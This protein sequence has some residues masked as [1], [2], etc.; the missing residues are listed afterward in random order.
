MKRLLSLTLLTSLALLGGCDLAQDAYSKYIKPS[1]ATLNGYTAE[2]DASGAPTGKV[3]LNISALDNN[4]EPIAGD[5]SKPVVKDIK[6]TSTGGGVRAAQTY[7]ATAEIKFDIKV[8]EIV[9][10][11]LDIDQSGSMKQTD[12]ARKRVDAA[13]SFIGRIKGDDRLA[14]MTFQGS[15]EGYRASSLL[16][17]FTSDKTALDAAVQKVGQ[18]N[19]TPIW[20]SVLDTLDLHDGDEGG[21]NA[22]RVVVLFT[23]GQRNGG[24]VNFPEALGAASES[25][26]KFFT[27]GLGAGEKQ[28]DLT[29]L[30]KLAEDTGGTF[31]NVADASGLE[32]LFE[33][34]FNAIRASG[35]ITLDISPVPP[36]GSLVTGTIQFEVNGETFNLPYAVQL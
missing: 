11:V 2:R 22:S 28:L 34:I 8:E 36:A 14:V 29:E 24:T 30:Q 15:D 17:D 4:G 1:T 6:V 3:D 33:K 9:N 12:P 27:V 25:G 19:E 10:A 18:K 32:A 20:D 26:V 23:D 5:I 21:G 31:A 16:Q 7:A 13:E 35:V